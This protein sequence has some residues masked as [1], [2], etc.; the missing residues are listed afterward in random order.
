MRV[1]FEV[2]AEDE[3]VEDIAGALVVHGVRQVHV[4]AHSY[5]TF[6]AS[7]L[8]QL[9]KVMVA[10][11]TLLDPV[12]LKEGRSGANSGRKEGRSRFHCH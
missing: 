5:G 6:M 9:H 3:I 1:C 10:S 12:G 7:R 4:V 8:V 2:P 11:L